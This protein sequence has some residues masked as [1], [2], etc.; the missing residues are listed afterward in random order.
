MFLRTVK[1]RPFKLFQQEYI[2]W[3]RA[4][5]IDYAITLILIIY[6]QLVNNVFNHRWN[7]KYSKIIESLKVDEKLTPSS[8]KKSKTH[9]FRAF[10]FQR[11]IFL[12][13]VPQAA[14]TANKIKREQFSGPFASPIHANV[15]VSQNCIHVDFLVFAGVPR[16]S[17]SPSSHFSPHCVSVPGA[18]LIRDSALDLIRYTAVCMP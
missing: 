7:I 9:P 4:W 14:F 13:N 17:F 12:F 11:I 10:H 18:D 2:M 5:Y 15:S 1:Y 6:Q 3:R 8:W 16:M